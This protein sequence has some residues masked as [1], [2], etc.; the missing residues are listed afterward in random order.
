MTIEKRLD[1]NFKKKKF[2]GRE[3]KKNTLCIIM[4]QL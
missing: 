3:S 1:Q 2:Y 4:F